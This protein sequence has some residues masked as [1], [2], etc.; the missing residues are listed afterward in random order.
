ME[1]S[2]RLKTRVKKRATGDP[3]PPKQGLFAQLSS[4][5]SIHPKKRTRQPSISESSEVLLDNF[6]KL[7]V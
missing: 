4:E 2:S 1:S 3:I 7:V 5:N 6:Y